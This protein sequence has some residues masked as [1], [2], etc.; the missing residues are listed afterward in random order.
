MRSN[1]NNIDTMPTRSKEAKK[2]QRKEEEA[3]AVATLEQEKEATT[4]QC[5][6]AV[7]PSGPTQVMSEAPPTSVLSPP[8][9][10][11]LNALLSGQDGQEC[12]GTDTNTSTITADSEA[13]KENSASSNKKK[14]KKPKEKSASN[15]LS[16]SKRDSSGSVLKQG[17]FATAAA[18]TAAPVAASK[19]FNYKQVY[20]EAGL[21]MK[22]DNKYAAYVKQIGLLFKNIKLVDKMAIMHTSIKSETA[23]PL[24]SKSEMNDNM[25]IFLGYAPVGSNSNVFKPKKNN[26]KKKGQCGNHKPDMIKPSMCPTLIFSSNIDLNIITSQ[27]THEFCCAGGFYFRKKQLQCIELCTTFIIIYLYTFNDIAT[28]CSEL[29]SL[30]EL[31]YEGM[32]N[33]F[34]LPEEFE[35]HKLQEINIRK[36]V[37]KLP[38]QSGQ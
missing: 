22:G 16:S 30:L 7:T 9:T 34:I 8:S 27:V 32:Q 19:V 2:Q 5:T 4:R 1:F 14:T 26:N 33:N 29:N 20:N 18:S 24:G 31:A 13:V 17:R 25:T 37:P 6:A 35:H 11:N 15:K 38:N 21:Q 12:L 23:K 10:A 36:R 3:M 28:I